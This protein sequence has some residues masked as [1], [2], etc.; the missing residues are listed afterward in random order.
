MNFDNARTKGRHGKTE[1]NAT[2]STGRKER[3]RRPNYNVQTD[4]SDVGDG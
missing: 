3:K 4:R 1:E 2:V